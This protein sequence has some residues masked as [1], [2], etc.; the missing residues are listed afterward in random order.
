MIKVLKEKVKVKVYGEKVTVKEKVKAR[1]KAKKGVGNELNLRKERQS[2]G[3]GARILARMVTTASLTTHQIVRTGKTDGASG[4]KNVV[5]GT[6][7]V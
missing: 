4:I 6:S 5:S 7:R 1:V 3:I 2:A